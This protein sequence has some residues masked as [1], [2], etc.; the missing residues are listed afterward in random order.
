M[1]ELRTILP[2]PLSTGELVADA[3]GIQKVSLPASVFHGMWTFDIPATMWLMYENAAEVFTSTDITSVSGHA[4]LAT[5]VTNTVL[6]L[7]S[8]ECPRYQPNRGHLCSI[9]GWFPSKTADGIRDFGLIN[10]FNGVFFR[11]KADGLLYAVLLSGGV[12]TENLIPTANLP[13]GFN[14]EKNNIYDIQFQWRSAGNYKFFIGDA[15]TGASKLVYT[16]NHLNLFAAVSIENPALPIGF[17]ATR[18]TADVEMHIGCADVTSENGSVTNTEQYN[19]AYAANVSIGTTQP[20]IVIKQPLL[21]AGVT[22]TRT[23]TLARITV[24]CSKKGSFRVW[25]TRDPTAITGATFVAL[26]G[27]S[28]VETDSPDTAAGAVRATS[29]TTSAMKFV[30]AIQ[31][32]TLVSRSLDNPYRGRI[33][34][35]LVRGDYLV[36]TGTAATATAECVVEWGE[37]V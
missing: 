8:R 16:Y 37:Q 35:P 34:F 12:E 6:K 29:V 1:T 10:E 33:E 24:T 4:K 14:V 27:G 11:L 15:A 26:G 18:T 5:T 7:E 23:I 22:N 21:I 17:R 3:W 36:V 31:V 2:D 25:V 13:V 30:S 28:F 19:S 9:A 20:V 32:E